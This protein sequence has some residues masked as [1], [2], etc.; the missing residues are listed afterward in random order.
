MDTCFFGQ[1]K[2]AF[3]KDPLTGEYK[4]HQERSAIRRTNNKYDIQNKKL[5]FL[6]VHYPPL[7][8]VLVVVD[9]IQFN[10]YNVD[11]LSSPQ[12]NDDPVALDRLF[13]VQAWLDWVI[14][15][16]NWEFIDSSQRPDQI[17][18][19]NCGIF[20]IM[21]ADFWS[22]M[23]NPKDCYSSTDADFFRYKIAIDILRQKLFY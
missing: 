23:L 16:Q 18:H 22:D 4:Y 8:W 9:I 1:L 5:I 11:G 10:I 2:N 20:T 17:D 19:Y 7:H 21:T 14:G 13:L 6:P 3:L 12:Q 15:K